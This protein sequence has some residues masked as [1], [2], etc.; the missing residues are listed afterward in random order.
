MKN[1]NTYLINTCLKNNHEKNGRKEQ[2]EMELYE[3]TYPSD[4]SAGK[5]VSKLVS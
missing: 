5:L 1:E 4:A 2:A 3:R